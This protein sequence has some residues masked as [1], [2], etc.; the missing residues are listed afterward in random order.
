[1]ALLS[2]LCKDNPSGQSAGADGNKKTDKLKKK[3]K[4]TAILALALLL[5]LPLVA[6]NATDVLSTARR[7]NNYFMAKYADPTLPTFV[8]KVRTSN[9]WTRSVYYEG[10]MALYAIDANPSYAEYTDRWASFHKWAPRSSANTTNADDQCCGQVYLAR[11][12][13]TGRK[14]A[15][16]AEP[17]LANLK[18]Q[19][20]SGKL[21]YWTWIDAIQMA[22]PIYAMATQITGDRDYIDHAMRM[23]RWTR[24]ECGGGLY[25]RKNGF[26]WR[27]ADFVPPYKEADGNDCYWSRGDGWVYA[28]LVR[29]MSTLDK[30]D[31]YYKELKKDFVAMSKAIAGCQREDGSWNVS[32]VS[33]ATFGG[34]ELTGTSLFVY[35]MAWGLRNGILKEKVYRPVVDKAWTAMRS[36]VHADGFL[37]Y[38]QGTGK[39]P[40]DSQ[41][42][43]D[44]HVPDFEDFGT[45]C[46]LLGATEYYKL[47]K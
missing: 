45:G 26:W 7:V 34:K 6:Q 4:K 2:Y 17:T 16:M 46:F 43:N 8:K 25:N 22:M 13:Q 41:P 29:V 32:L 24:N 42:V 23:Y 35:G 28:A 3:M 1:M 31:P 40:S 27:D 18:N 19:M 30:K 21:G 39:Q 38:I 15:G 44:T 20:E 12:E 47:I 10:L 14:D 9:L 5:A 11:Y 33:P 37:G 36:G